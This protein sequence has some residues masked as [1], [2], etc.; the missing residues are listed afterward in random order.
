MF[1]TGSSSSISNHNSSSLGSDTRLRR[2]QS[3]NLYENFSCDN[4][5]RSGDKSQR[6]DQKPCEMCSNYEQQL[7]SMQKRE[8]DLLKQI[9]LSQETIKSRKDDLHREEKFRHELEDKFSEEAKE[10]EK[11]ILSL[12][13]RVESS[14][15]EL[16]E[17]RS[18]LHGYYSEASREI[19]SLT[20]NKQELNRQLQ[21]LL[22][23]NELLLGKH[24]AQSDELQ[25]ETIDLPENLEEMQFYCLKL[26]EDL[27]TAL[28]AK[29]RTQETCRSDMLFLKEQQQS[30]Q[31]SKETIIHTLTEEAGRL[32]S[33]LENTRSR[34]KKLK[35]EHEE[36]SK[37]LFENETLVTES[38][39]TIIKLE[40]EVIDLNNLRIALEEENS[41]LKARVTD[42]QAGLENSEQVQKDFV[43]LSQNLQI[44]LEKIR[45]ADTE[46]RWQHEEDIHECGNCKKALNSRKEKHHCCHCGKIFCNECNSKTIRG[47]PNNRV[48]KVCSVCHTLLNRE[49]APYFSN[50]LPQSPT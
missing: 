9:E 7:Q 13:E 31:R 27:I 8:A 44:E 22:A 1:I 30:E 35:K 28:V 2:S 15:K 19:K 6:N 29:E 5:R 4:T 46:V 16:P 12:K 48:F 42:L 43:K 20:D 24:I 26:K 38:Q 50:E 10:V 25:A 47:G 18:L 39:R 23:E 33:N 32:R 14:S 11:K 45:Q 34:F 40:K 49:T 21:K 17:I 37:K 3:L 36:A 41:T